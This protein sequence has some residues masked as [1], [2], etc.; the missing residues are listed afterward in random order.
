MNTRHQHLVS[1]FVEEILNRGKTDLIGDLVSEDHILHGPDGDLY[2]REGVRI[3][4]MEYR[5][6]FPDLRVQPYDF[7]DDGSWVSCRFLL[8]GT[9]SGP[10][11]GVPGSGSPVEV[12][13]TVV[14][15]VEHDR[16]VE[17]WINIDG[18]GLAEQIA[19]RVPASSPQ[20]P[21]ADHV[22]R[23]QDRPS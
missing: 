6:G 9:H 23:I 20:L 2:G 8:C 21:A 10:Y 4:V 15:R 16:L 18:L 5:T 3:A 11:R 7:A 12:M 17:S 14:D 22:N 13:G 19:S 1:R